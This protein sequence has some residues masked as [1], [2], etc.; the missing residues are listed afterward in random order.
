MFEKLRRPVK[1]KSFF[2]YLI[3]GLIAL[4]FVFIGFDPQNFGVQ[5]KGAVA[6]V[7]NKYISMLDYQEALQRMRE[8]QKQ[9][10]DLTQKEEENLKRQVLNELIHLE[11]LNQKAYEEGF[12]VSDVEV[13]NAISQIPVFQER[14]IFR[15]DLYKRYIEFTRS[16]AFEFENKIKKSLTYSKVFD[17]FNSSLKTTSAEAKKQHSIDKIRFEVDFFFFDKSQIRKNLSW[18]KKQEKSFFKSLSNKAVKDFYLKNKNLFQTKESVKLWQILI[19]P[20]KK[21]KKSHE[22]AYQKI[23]NLAL[24]LTKENFSKVARENS[25]DALSRDQGGFL[26]YVKK[27][28]KNLDFEEQVFSLKEGEISQVFK[29]SEAYHIVWVEEKTQAK[30]GSLEEKRP[31]VLKEMFI[32]EKIKSNLEKLRHNLKSN[33]IKKVEN[34]VKKY[35]LKWESTGPFGL[36]QTEFPKILKSS[37]LFKS[38]LQSELKEGELFKELNISFGKFYVLKAKKI[39]K[40]KEEESSP[41][42]LQDPFQN[43]IRLSLNRSIFSNWIESLKQ[44]SYIKKYLNSRL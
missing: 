11:L 20:K 44:K 36:E 1:A 3:L 26:G 33:Q 21:T 23:K 35:Q 29:T 4:V 7:N 32:R 15:R 40:L 25:E 31:D 16:T 13:R 28:E 24:N 34:F 18:D 43:F 17:S 8:Q 12:F 22:E 41:K 30:E 38:F 10:K 9:S 39:E 37:K 5:Q 2:S 19:Q 42:T 6:L 27:G 14:G